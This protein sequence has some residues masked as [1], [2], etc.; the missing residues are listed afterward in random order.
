MSAEGSIQPFA[1]DWRSFDRE[2]ELY[3]TLGCNATAAIDAT[4]SAAASAARSVASPTTRKTSS[5]MI[6]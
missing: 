4:D 6:R 2:R 5:D 1:E 3:S